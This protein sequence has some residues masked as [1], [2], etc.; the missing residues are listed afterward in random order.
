M[1]VRVTLTLP[2]Q[3]TLRWAF[4]LSAGMAALAAAVAGVAVA[5]TMAPSQRVPFDRNPNPSPNPKPIPNPNPNPNPNPIPNPNP[6]PNPSPNPNP[7]RV[8]FKLRK[9]NPVSCVRLFSSGVEMRLLALLLAITLQPIFMGDVLQVTP[10][11]S[12][13][14]LTATLQ[15][16]YPYPISLL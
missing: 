16:T 14:T 3:H 12:L 15:E 1:R 7:R 9:F 13:G 5:E 10:N 6:S 11:P 8:P 2:S 4:G